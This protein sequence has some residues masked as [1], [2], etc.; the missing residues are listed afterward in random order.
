MFALVDCNN[1]YVSCERVFNPA[2]EG[3]A[4]VVLSNNDGCIIARSE[5]AKSLGI[6]MG[7]PEF[8]CRTQ[9]ADAGASVFSSNYPLYGDM[10]SR[11]MTVLADKAPD[12]EIYSID[13]AFLDL[14]GFGRFDLGDY[15]T[16]IR[17]TVRRHTGIP[18]SIGIG[19][20][21]TL[22]K[23]ANRIA[24]KNPE[25]HGVCVLGSDAEIRSALRQTA[26]GDVWGIGRQWSLL[27]QTGNI[28]TA[29][30]LAE[31]PPTWIRKHLHITGARVQAELLGQSCLPLE[32]ARPARQSIC[33]SRSFGRSVEHQD[34]LREAVATF[35]GNCARKLRREQLA[36]SMIT[37]FACT[38][39]FDPPDE[40]YWGT[41]TA[42]LPHPEQ[43]SRRLVQHAVKLLDAVFRK[44][45]AYKKAGVLVCGLVPGKTAATPLP[46]FPDEQP[47]S[48]DRQLRL[49]E[50]MEQINT[51]Y[52]RSTIHLASENAG[53]WKPRQQKLS[54]RYTTVW[55][56]IISVK[57]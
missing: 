41:R 3:R 56:E 38:S 16:T 49:M 30:D 47:E 32:L 12:I 57:A 46:L 39:P 35:A 55:D 26:V 53:A 48:D 22:A 40:R 28:R 52:G 50:A 36:A 14:S 31:A 11:V 51:R 17:R 6:K 13:E 34:E 19:P 29:A 45:Y 23:V 7:A 1:F 8:K 43:D 18:V 24:K 20:T 27:L 4:V 42:S 9:L 25:M 15:A 33:T 10:S 21:K 44:G 37:V 5:E 2:L 54:S